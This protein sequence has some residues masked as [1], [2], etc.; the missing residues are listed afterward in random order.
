[1]ELIKG[2]SQNQAVALETGFLV[3]LCSGTYI[4][5]EQKLEVGY[6][7]VQV[8]TKDLNI[9]KVEKLPSKISHYLSNK[10][11]EKIL[12]EDYNKATAE[13]NKYRDED[14][15]LYFPDLDTE[16]AVRK[17][18]EPFDK[19]RAIYSTPEEQVSHVEIKVIGSL[20]DTGSPYIHTPFHLGTK[21][22]PSG[23]SAGI[24]KVDIPGIYKSEYT[25]FKEA[26]PKTK[27]EEPSHSLLKYVKVDGKSIFSSLNGS[28]IEG[29]GFSIV[30]TLEEAKELES[31]ARLKIR[32]M[33]T[34]VV[35]NKVVT[36]EGALYAELLKIKNE[37]YFLSVK[38]HSENSKVSALHQLDKLV[39]N[40]E[41]YSKEQG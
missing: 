1:M 4:V 36:T 25:K 40:I 2:L 16:F 3:Q 18:F 21:C 35:L 26:H 6:S 38:K 5:N 29:K 19:A 27:F 37:V 34:T 10:T 15:D 9:S 24:Y 33:L 12:V 39:T 41:N 11:G 14:C 20:E 17:A 32:T 28:Y 23:S 22:W 31:S 30:S 13:L 7:G 8:V